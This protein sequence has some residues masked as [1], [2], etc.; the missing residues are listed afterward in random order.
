M[1]FAGKVALVTG[2]ET[3]IGRGTALALASRG[4]IVVIGGQIEAEGRAAVRAIGEAGGT[5]RFHTIDV[6]KSAD[7]ARLVEAA[8][9]EFGR[10]DLAFNNAGGQ[11]PFATVDETETAIADHW[12][13]VD[14]KGVFYCLK[15][16]IAAMLDH[17]GGAIVNTA[18]I[19]SLKACAHL[20]HYVAAK[21]GVVGLTRAA[22]LDYADKGV[23]INAV[24]PGPIKT[25]S[26]D[27]ASGGDDSLYAAFAPMKR[28]GQP[29]DIADAVMWLLSDEAAFVTGAIMAIDGGMAAG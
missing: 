24:C 25:P 23:R 3:G 27:R 14:L 22:A 8:I 6:A 18:S 11:G 29:Q 12:I 16:E 17:G 4:A 19:F 15:Y 13:G 7:C 9:G 20:A 2:G 10:L 21:H 1:T 26:L 5:A 28:V